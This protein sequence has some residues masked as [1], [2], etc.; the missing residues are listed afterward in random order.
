M[1]ISAQ[2]FRGAVAGLLVALLPT[3][4]PAAAADPEKPLQFSAGDSLGDLGPRRPAKPAPASTLPR[5]ADGK[6]DLTGIWFAGIRDF[7]TLDDR[8]IEIPLTPDYA[9]VRARR[10]KAMDEGKPLPDYVSTCQAFGMPRIMSYGVMEFVH[11]PQQLW[12]ISEVMHEV[13]RIYLDGKPH[14]EWQESTF[15]GISS[16]HWEGETLVVE[17]RKLR[18]GFMSMTGIPYS[19]RLVVTERIRMVTRDAIENEM[20]LTDPVALTQPWKVVQ[21]YD[22]K[23]PGYEIGEFICNEYNVSGGSPADVDPRKDLPASA[24]SGA[25]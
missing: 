23:E 19:D 20:M 22:R 4:L 13:R 12:V 18:P 6:P 21:R 9:A 7:V 17:T 14:G 11:R 16:G 15:G 10:V 24:I 8:R 25:P 5:G 3:C 2:S 1:R